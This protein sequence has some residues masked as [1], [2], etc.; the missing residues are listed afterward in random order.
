[1]NNLINGC[2]KAGKTT[3]NSQVTIEELRDSG[4]FKMY[5]GGSD[6]VRAVSAPNVLSLLGG[7]FL[8]TLIFQ[9]GRI[10]KVILNP[11][12]KDYPM[13]NYPDEAYQRR[14][15]EMCDQWL[16]HNLGKPER[17]NEGQTSYRFHWGTIGAVSV[18]EGKDRYSGGNIMISYEGGPHDR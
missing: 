5:E 6:M 2:V 9:A 7:E 13:P 4:L 16:E 12:L 18:L 1:M 10:K 14:K 17:K 8:I 11:V 3:I 15:R